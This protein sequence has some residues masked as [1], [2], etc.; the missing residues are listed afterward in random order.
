MPNGFPNL[1]WLNLIVAV[2]VSSKWAY[3]DFM[4][5]VQLVKEQ[6]PAILSA[7][8]QK[9]SLILTNMESAFAMEFLNSLGLDAR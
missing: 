3:T 7:R 1:L 6:Q 9:S 4:L 8:L 2:H 5:C